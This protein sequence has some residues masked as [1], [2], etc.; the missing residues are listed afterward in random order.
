MPRAQMP[1]AWMQAMT[2]P[3]RLRLRQ[4]NRLFALSRTLGRC[5]LR[6]KLLP[7]GQNRGIRRD[8]PAT[9]PVAAPTPRVHPP[10]GWARWHCQTVGRTQ[11]CPIPPRTRNNKPARRLA[12]PAATRV[13]R[14]PARDDQRGITTAT[15]STGELAEAAITGISK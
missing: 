5:C 7:A 3:A 11:P 10:H 1:S 14:L 15:E 9:R 2:R 4:T 12:S 13:S 6:H 8:G